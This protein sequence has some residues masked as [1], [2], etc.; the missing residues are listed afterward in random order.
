M[1]L[2]MSD[3]SDKNEIT[4]DPKSVGVG[5]AGSQQ[6]NTPSSDDC[7]AQILINQEIMGQLHR[8]SQRLDK[9]EDGSKDKKTSD[10]TKIKN[11]VHIKHTASPKLKKNNPLSWGW[12]L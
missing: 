9:L 6:A 4:S 1:L 5:G 12:G 8:V 2:D 7:N 11:K 10:P 3:N